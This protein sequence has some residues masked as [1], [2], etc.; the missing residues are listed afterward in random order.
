MNFRQQK[1][2]I[3]GYFVISAYRVALVAAVVVFGILYVVQTSAISTTGYDRRDLER[4]ITELQRDNQRTEYEI[5]KYR[6]MNSIQARLAK[7][8]MVA[9]ENI[10]YVALVGTAVARR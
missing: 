3:H 4:K 6:S 5:A 10:R 2:A 9:A 8:D 7:T 1:I